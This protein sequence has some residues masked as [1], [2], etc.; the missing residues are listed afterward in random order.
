VIKAS[1]LVLLILGRF[2][3]ILKSDTSLGE[4]G[5][6]LA[7]PALTIPSHTCDGLDND[8]ALA[9][10]E[11]ASVIRSGASKQR[12]RPCPL[13]SERDQQLTHVGMSLRAKNDRLRRG[14]A[15]SLF[16]AGVP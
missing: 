14:K 11:S 1:A 3:T 4:R 16:A 7:R 15:A 10:L 13:C 6:Y 2:A 9:I 5:S 8:G 12:A